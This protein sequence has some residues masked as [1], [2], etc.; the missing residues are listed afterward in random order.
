M[1]LGIVSNDFFYK[2][3]A[4]MELIDYVL[5]LKTLDHRLQD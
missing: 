1:Q 5:I 3:N 2:Q 4:P